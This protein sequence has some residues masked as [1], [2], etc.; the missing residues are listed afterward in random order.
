MGH[1]PKAIWP[2]RYTPHPQPPGPLGYVVDTPEGAMGRPTTAHTDPHG[3]LGDVYDTLA[4]YPIEQP[5][6]DGTRWKG[7]QPKI[8][9]DFDVQAGY[10]MF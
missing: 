7:T 8:W 2:S 3:P 9:H 5:D 1:P 6:P 10:D 4:E